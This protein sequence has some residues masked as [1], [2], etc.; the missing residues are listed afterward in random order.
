MLFRSWNGRLYTTNYDY[1]IKVDQVELDIIVVEQP[2]PFEEDKSIEDS[3][4][5]LKYED[6]ELSEKTSDKDLALNTN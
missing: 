2:Y 3:V 5:P 1:E 4:L 6:R